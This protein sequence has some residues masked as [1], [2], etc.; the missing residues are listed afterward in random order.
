MGYNPDLKRISVA[1]Y[2]ELLRNQNLLPGRRILQEDLDAR[3]DAILK[4]GAGNLHELKAALATPEKLAAF[5]AKTQMTTDYLTILKR[6]M[7]SFE[8]KPVPLGEFPETEKTLLDG[9]AKEGIRTSKDLFEHCKS[10]AGETIPADAAERLTALCDLV[11]INGVGALAAVTFYEAGYRSV[12]DVANADA[13]E[14]LRK[15]CAVNEEKQYY[16]AKLGTKDMQFCIDYA[17][18]LM[19]LV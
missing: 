13:G 19:K 5:A 18:T 7:G 1:D 17:R 9:L 11:R 16:K 14:M 6:E 8:Q 4:A 2:R 15:V 10:G 12:R 3:F